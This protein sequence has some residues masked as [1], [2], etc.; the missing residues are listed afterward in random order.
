M[1]T[2]T[3]LVADIAA[4]AG[5][6]AVRVADEAAAG[7][8]AAF[9]A[10]AGATSRRVNITRAAAA[11]LE[12]AGIASLDAVVLVADRPDIATPINQFSASLADHGV[13][14]IVLATGDA[15]AS[16]VPRLGGLLTVIADEDPRRLLGILEGVLTRQ[17][18][19]RRL[20]A[21]LAIARRGH[22]GLADEMER[23]NEELQL[24]ATMQREL[25][26]SAMPD[27]LGVRIR[28]LWR[29]ATYVSG[30]VYAVH[31]LDEDRIG[32]LMADWFGHGVPAALITMSLSR[33]FAIHALAGRSPRPPHEVLAR[34]NQDMTR[35]RTATT[36]FAT[37]IYAII[38]C[39]RR[40]MEIA[41]AGHP[42]ALLYGP[43]GFEQ[44]VEGDGPLLGVFEDAEFVSSRVPIPAD[45][46]LL[47]Y[48]DGFEQAFV[49]DAAG[50]RRGDAEGYKRVF[51][52]LAP[53]RDPEQMVA[54][55]EEQLDAA[56]GSL[57]QA[58]DLT[59]LCVH[60]A[61]IA[62]T[63]PTPAAVVSPMRPAA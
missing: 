44:E 42:P 32:I 35:S 33:S 21:E 26:P 11:S 4:N 17:G 23:L 30:D 14:T 12:E 28:G 2:R 16:L 51:S 52:R 7:L 6:P 19:V 40:E 43:D 60:A 8:R 36:R 62:A 53:L 13:A 38:D 55:L 1:R 47:L 50:I 22:G 24:A 10:S 39:R 57:H 3:I 27:R 48:T 54:A 29:P 56:A 18:E 59:L 25:L 5:D 41:S 15:A 58:D 63:A 49:D 45:A 9:A 20:E 34:L 61:P 46:T 37:A 31:E